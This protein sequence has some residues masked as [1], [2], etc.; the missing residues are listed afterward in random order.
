MGEVKMKTRRFTR[1]DKA[2]FWIENYCHVPD[3]P[4]KGQ[5]V[6]L[7]PAEHMQLLRIY[8]MGELPSEPISGALG[9]YLA[10]LHICSPEALQQHPL[11][12]DVEV[13]SWTIWR[14]ASPKLHEVLR[15]EGEHVVCPELGTRYPSA[16]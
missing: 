5:K 1:S 10:L 15:R 8:D 2:R 6:I 13:D 7:T 11:R 9:A 16:A 3:G 4:N 14:A 12:P